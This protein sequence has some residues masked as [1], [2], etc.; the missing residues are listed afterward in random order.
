[1]I[2]EA[3]SRPAGFRYAPKLQSIFYGCSTIYRQKTRRC[4]GRVKTSVAYMLPQKYVIYTVDQL[5]AYTTSVGLCCCT[6][7]N[8]RER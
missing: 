2:H 3:P 5:S 6:R 7:D 8:E 1:M 4:M